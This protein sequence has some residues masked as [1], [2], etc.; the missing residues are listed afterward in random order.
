MQYRYLIIVAC[1]VLSSC[2][3]TPSNSS[4]N[5]CSSCYATEDLNGNQGI[6]CTEYVP[7][8]TVCFGGLRQFSE[9]EEGARAS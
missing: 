4:G 5:T 2:G 9:S 7:S 6:E 8:G 3:T 1:F